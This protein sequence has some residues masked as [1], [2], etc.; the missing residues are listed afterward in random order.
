MP[1]SAPGDAGGDPER[2]PALRLP[3][4]RLRIRARTRRLPRVQLI[5]PRIARRKAVQE[6]GRGDVFQVRRKRPFRQPVSQ[7]TF[8]FP[9][10]SSQSQVKNKSSY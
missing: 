2:E 9:E 4:P 3:Q 8:G 7:G 6:S 10:Q 1:Q 5:Q